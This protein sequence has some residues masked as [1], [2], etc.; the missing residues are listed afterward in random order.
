[1]FVNTLLAMGQII[2]PAPMD[3]AVVYFARPSSNGL[4]ANFSYY[5]SI[6]F[7]GRFNGQK[8]I[9]Y[10]CEPGSHLFWAVSEKKDFVEAEVE[11]GKI[12][13]I[14]ANPVMGVTKVR[15]ELL[16]I[17]P[18]DEDMMGIILKLINKKPP[19]VFSQSTLD[20]GTNEDQILKAIEEYKWEKGKG[21]KHTRLEKSMYYKN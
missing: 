12:Y 13:F 1:M 16:P 8:Y 19:V 20:E 15:V 4:P 14:L 2:G 18:S 9:R 21:I 10:E 5:D 11:A 3:K 7:I 6:K 17:D